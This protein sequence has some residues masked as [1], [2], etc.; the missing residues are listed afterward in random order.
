MTQDPEHA[1][2][3]VEAQQKAERDGK[4]QSPAPSMSTWSPTV[5]AI[6]TVAD[7]LGSLIYLMRAS[8]GDK[9]A[10]PMKP[11]P[12]PETMLPEIQRKKRQEQHNALAAR[13]LGR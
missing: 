12:R 2:M 13:L 4:Q 9:Q 10:K 8:N 3:L 11:M 7:R 5:E 6:T 1:A